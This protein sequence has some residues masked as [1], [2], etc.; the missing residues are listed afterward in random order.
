MSEKRI[1]A[2]WRRVA[3]PVGAALVP[4]AIAIGL[5]VFRVAL[6][7]AENPVPAVA[8]D[9][10]DYYYPTYEAAAQVIRS[11]QLPLWDP[12]QLCGTPWLA[13][14]QGGFLYPPNVVFLLLDTHVAM[15]VSAALHL[16]VVAI[17]VALLCA[18]LGLA[19]PFASLAALLC[20]GRGVWPAMVGA[21]NAL[22]A[23]AWLPWGAMGALDLAR[24]R[25]R[26]GVISLSLSCAA[27]LLAGYPQTTVYC[28]YA[29]A[30]L[31][32]GFLLVERSPWRASLRAVLAFAGACAIGFLLAAPQLLPALELQALGTRTLGG[33]PAAPVGRPSPAL[34]DALRGALTRRLVHPN[35]LMLTLGV[36]PLVLAP[37]CLLLRRNFGVVLATLVPGA[38]ALVFALGP[39]T[40]LYD[41]MIELP[42]LDSFRF[43]M[44][45]LFLTDFSLA[46][47]LAAGLQALLVR[48]AIARPAIARPALDRPAK[49]DGD[50]PLAWSRP[51]TQSLIR[52]A[53]VLVALAAGSVAIAQ[54]APIAAVLAALTAATIAASALL[55]VRQASL[56]GVACVVLFAFELGLAG[57]YP[58]P[59]P[60]RQE[61]VAAYHE[62]RQVFAP[63][64]ESTQRV[65]LAGAQLA[66]VPT[67]PRLPS[68]LGFHSI[69]AYEPL[70]LVRQQQYF[71]FLEH[72]TSAPQPGP[73]P[74]AGRLT[75]AQRKKAS[76]EALEERSRLL[77]LAAT[78]WLLTTKTTLRMREHL[79]RYTERPS[80]KRVLADRELLLFE[81]TT[82]LPRA[83]VTY[84]TAQ[85]PPT[86][87]L[88]HLLAAKSFDPL[89]TTYV[90]GPVEG[91]SE[92]SVERGAEGSAPPPAARRTERRG[93]PAEILSDLPDR[94]EIGANLEADG[95][96]VLA[97]SYYPGWRATVDG[98][99][100]EILPAN[101]LFRA[102]AVPAGLHTI[103]FEYRP[104]S[105]TWGLAACALGAALLAAWIRFAGSAANAGSR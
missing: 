38:L 53:C 43:K 86:E 51:G 6:P 80:I 13:T 1:E 81:N 52:I 31:L 69:D 20:A 8:D 62:D 66:S 70:N 78:R 18:R 57:D 95:M 17:G 9:L 88:L 60:Y 30:V 89:R 41:L 73:Q 64:R 85:A 96:V 4:A 84:R 61:P 102:V 23:S 42:M 40:P 21:P 58:R 65:W 29:W 98:R 35:D 5:W 48:P 87:E 26:S 63:L 76:P 14:M 77:D 94:V 91:S 44:R 97:D 55:S 101:H 46:I 79:R 99:P 7:G 92:G 2:G 36:V 103:R 47:V 37:T 22:A 105:F 3:L 15:A 49:T 10:L 71:G 45:I 72:G 68:V 39:A 16:G 12:N 93:H 19:A 104:P 74:W 50:A 34:L 11:G 67:L 32:V 82:A 27:S 59:L 28:L 24:G 75:L 33:L 54:S 56:V 90:E 100:V 83:F 25:V